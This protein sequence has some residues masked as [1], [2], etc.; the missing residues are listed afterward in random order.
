MTV[1][2]FYS[3]F[4]L[5]GKTELDQRAFMYSAP[6]ADGGKTHNQK[7]TVSLHEVK[8]IT[9]HVRADSLRNKL[10]FLLQWMFRWPF[11][12]CLITCHLAFYLQLTLTYDLLLV[13]HKNHCHISNI[14]FGRGDGMVAYQSS[15]MIGVFLAHA[16]R[17]GSANQMVIP[18]GIPMDLLLLSC[19]VNP[20]L[21]TKHGSSFS[22]TQ[23]G[24]AYKK[25]KVL[26][27][28]NWQTITLWSIK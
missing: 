23:S 8:M 4:L 19:Q 27:L 1:E 6:T 13:S 16:V 11:T 20:A 2:V 10:F 9:E 22:F 7:S 3:P 5:S 21:Q 25:P 12:A 26:F 14:T 28:E 24:T 18:N 17:R 15:P